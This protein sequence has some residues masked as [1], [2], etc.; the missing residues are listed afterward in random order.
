MR[1]LVVE[2]ELHLQKTNVYY[3]LKSETLEENTETKTM[4]GRSEDRMFKGFL[5]DGQPKEFL[6]DGCPIVL[7]KHN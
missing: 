1:I 3:F 5:F 7:R 2:D 6:S 4:T